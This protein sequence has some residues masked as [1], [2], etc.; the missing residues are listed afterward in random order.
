M[1]LQEK[2]I[3]HDLTIDENLLTNTFENA[4]NKCRENKHEKLI[5]K[6]QLEERIKLL[7]ENI[8][9]IY[10]E[11]N[12]EQGKILRQIIE[13]YVIKKQGLVLGHQILLIRYYFDKEQHKE[14]CE[15]GMKVKGTKLF[16][17]NEDK[18]LMKECLK[19]HKKYHQKQVDDFLFIFLEIMNVFI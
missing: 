14:S 3:E 15:K 18:E 10:T 8:I 5:R 1:E 17:N 11:K 13:D 2:L 19:I 7:L 6:K 12:N 16:F 4:L 9:K